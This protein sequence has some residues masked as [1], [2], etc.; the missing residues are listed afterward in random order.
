MRTIA[1]FFSGPVMF[2]AG[3]NHFLNP[4]FYEK[5]IPEGL[6]APTALVYISGVAEMVG[7]LATMHPRTRRAGGWILL[8][9][10]VS[11]FPANVWMALNAELFPSIPQCALLARLPL[12]L[13]FLY[14]V[15]IGT[16]R[17]HDA[18]SSRKTFA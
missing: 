3:L 10:L 7:A 12:Q 17:S 6:P 13:L 9:T 18:A 5:I 1:R 16:L 8:G 4:S 15:W 2:A 11:V 14:L